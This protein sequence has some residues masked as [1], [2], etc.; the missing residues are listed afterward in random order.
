MNH[1]CSP[2]APLYPQGTSILRNVTCTYADTDT[3][4]VSVILN[5][6]KSAATF[7]SLF[8]NTAL[9]QFLLGQF[10]A[11]VREGEGMSGQQD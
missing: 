5:G 8:N 4:S 2:S 1:Y 9:A 7:C 11:Q 3:A 6:P 10:N